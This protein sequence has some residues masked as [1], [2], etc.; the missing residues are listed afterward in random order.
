MSEYYTRKQAA[1]AAA[2]GINLSQI[3][4]GFVI[5][6]MLPLYLT[7]VINRTEFLCYEVHHLF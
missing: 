6:V 7:M 5:L 4:H 3:M 2:V 1:A